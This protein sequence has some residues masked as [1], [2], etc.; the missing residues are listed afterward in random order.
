MKSSK[1]PLLTGVPQGSIL[2][3]SLFVIFSNDFHDCL[4]NPETII[5]VDDTVV[6]CAASDIK[7]IERKINEEFKYIA[8][9]HDDSE[10]SD[11]LW[12]RKD[13]IYAIWYSEKFSIANNFNV[14]YRFSI[15]NQ[16]TSYV[17][18]GNTIDSSLNLNENFDKKCEKASGRT[19]LLTKV[20]PYLN[21]AAVFDIFNMMIVP[22]LTYCSILYHSWH[23]VALLIWIAL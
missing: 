8:Q 1:Y 5:Y 17:Y 21:Q 13:R 15:K 20:R 11:Q 16:V 14:F 3:T 23:T 4:K 9:Y 10:F 12:K 19:R 22:L 18:L 2:G 7:I 6:Y